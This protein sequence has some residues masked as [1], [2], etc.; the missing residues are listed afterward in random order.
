MSKTSSPGKEKGK[1]V[2][3]ETGWSEWEWQI[4]GC[5]WAKCRTT[6]SGEIEYKY[7]YPNQANAVPPAQIPRSDVQ[8][9]YSSIPTEGQEGST[10]HANHYY[11]HSRYPSAGTGTYNSSNAIEST[12]YSGQYNNAP[13]SGNTYYDSSS[14]YA[15]PGPQVFYPPPTP[16]NL[17]QGFEQLSFNPTSINGPIYEDQSTGDFSQQSMFNCLHRIRQ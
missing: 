6:A 9:S 3:L 4:A 17:A 11:K 1:S 10:E 14:S 13:I 12:Y 8:T 2:S 16:D 15:T 7:D 5:Y